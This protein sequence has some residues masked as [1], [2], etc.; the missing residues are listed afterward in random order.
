VTG[1]NRPFQSARE[2]AH[3]RFLE[4]VIDEGVEGMFVNGRPVEPFPSWL[5]RQQHQPWWRRWLQA[6]RRWR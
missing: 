6:W 3:R 1:D 5:A 2:E 4:R